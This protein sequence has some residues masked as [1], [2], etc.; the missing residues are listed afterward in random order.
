MDVVVPK[1]IS[2]IEEA[3]EKH[4]SIKNMMLSLL[5]KADHVSVTK[6]KLASELFK[7]YL[8]LK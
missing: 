5:E 3:L 8:E 6:E 7:I 1:G 4:R 2:L